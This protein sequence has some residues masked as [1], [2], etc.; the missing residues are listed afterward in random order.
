MPD[1]F[2]AVP[3]G[4]PEPWVSWLPDSLIGNVIIIS[5]LAV[6][7]ILVA[8]HTQARWFCLHAFAN[9]LCV[10]SALNSIFTCFTDPVHCADSSKYSDTS[11]FGAA[12]MWPVVI[13]NSVHVYHVIAFPLNADERF[14]H[15][16]FIPTIGFSGQYYSWGAA[17]GTI[18]FFLSGL[19]GG[20]DYFNL[21]LVKHAKMSLMTQKRICANLNVWCRGPGILLASFIMYQC[22]LYGT[23]TV[24][25]P[26]AAVICV[27]STF[28]GLYYTKQSVANYAFAHTVDTLRKT[29]TDEFDKSVDLRNKMLKT[30][31]N[32][33]S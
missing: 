33:M 30:P 28:N 10:I 6:F 13:T 21:L 26:L 7:D 16:L 20:I 32:A 17:Q 4:S 12:S 5:V 3:Q 2:T 9:L 11:L 18:A 15:Y 14:H 29:S 22:T 8:R 27:V 19:P 31:Q 24:P 1:I 25:A 23:T